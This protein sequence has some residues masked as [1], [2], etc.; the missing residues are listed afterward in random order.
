[1]E[2]SIYIASIVSLI[3]GLW[4][5]FSFSKIENEKDPQ[6]EKKDKCRICGYRVEHICPG[7]ETGWCKF[8]FEGKRDKE[9]LDY[10]FVNCISRHCLKCRAPELIIKESK[11]KKPMCFSCIEDSEDCC[12]G[13]IYQCKKCRRTFCK[14][15]AKLTEYENAFNSSYDGECVFC[16]REEL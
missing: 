12:I 11:L 5:L 15:H 16:L 7:C 13:S 2:Y 14:Y 3:F 9:Y 6:N 4:L 1:M 8:D 10:Y